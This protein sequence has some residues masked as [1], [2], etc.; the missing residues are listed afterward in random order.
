MNP[1]LFFRA[2][3]G[4]TPIFMILIF[5]ATFLYGNYY[6]FMSMSDM[7]GITGI[8][9][10][11]LVLHNHGQIIKE[12]TETEFLNYKAEEVRMSTANSMLFYGVGTGILYPTLK[13]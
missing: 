9:D 2:L 1:K 3:F 10:G 12:L 11:K 6:G 5:I 4:E 7:V 13:K 8:I